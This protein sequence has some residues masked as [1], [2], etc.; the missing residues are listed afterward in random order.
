MYCFAKPKL[1]FTPNR[2]IIDFLSWFRHTRRSSYVFCK[3]VLISPKRT[4][5]NQ[6]S[7]HRLC[8]DFSGPFT[9]LSCKPYCDDIQYKQDSVNVSNDL[10]GQSHLPDIFKGHGHEEYEQKR[11]PFTPSND[12]QPIHS[13]FLLFLHH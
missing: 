1:N 7:H 11:R 6:G 5:G 3:Y 12:P 13:T 8:P 4:K 2:F 10:I 9:L